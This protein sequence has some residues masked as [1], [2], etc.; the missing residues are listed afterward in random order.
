MLATVVQGDEAEEASPLPRLGAVEHVEDARW[1]VGSGCGTRRPEAYSVGL[2]SEA[3]QG[4]RGCRGLH[5]RGVGR[6]TTWLHTVAGLGLGAAA[7]WPGAG[8][9]AVSAKDG[10][11]DRA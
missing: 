10:A 6:G 2:G 9:A 8:V 7:V 3:W 1:L 5:D 4:R 11:S